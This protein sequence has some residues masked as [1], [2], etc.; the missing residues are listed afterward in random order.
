MIRI[1]IADDHTIVRQGLK[2]IL[3]E[4]DEL[5]ITDEASTG[6]ELIKKIHSKDFD[7]VL[8]DI[9]M[10]GKEV[11]DTIYD[12]KTYKPNLPILILTMNP[13]N[14]YAVRLFKAGASGYIKKDVKP[15]ELIE[16]IKIVASGNK[17]LSPVVSQLLVNEVR[18]KK[19]VLPHE[20]LTDREFQILIMIVEGKSLKEMSEILCLSKNTVSNHRHHLL[21]KMN[22]ANN[23]EI[24]HYAMKNK[25]IE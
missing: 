23:T 13:E 8:L 3:S 24:V 20:T 4:E 6:D 11:L 14:I 19:N 25:L 9:G 15:V 21:K 10:P 2:L 16:A 18:I 7:L 12:I 17:Y 1:I 5:K 22:L